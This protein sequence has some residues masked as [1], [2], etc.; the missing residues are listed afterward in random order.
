ML[1]IALTNQFAYYKRYGIDHKICF[2][3]ICNLMSI[4][5]PNCHCDV[6]SKYI[7]KSYVSA[8]ALCTSSCYLSLS[9]AHS[10]DSVPN[11]NSEQVLSIFDV[12]SRS[13]TDPVYCLGLGPEAYFQTSARGAGT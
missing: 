7:L 11:N 13:V 8:V 6:S 9:P 3:V 1:K 10:Q 2:Q 5:W 4:I 12:Y